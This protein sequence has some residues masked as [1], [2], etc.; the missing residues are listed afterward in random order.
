MSTWMASRP[1]TDG[2]TREIK[3]AT[4]VRTTARRQN[5][6]TKERD[7]CYCA[8]KG[9][10]NFG[11]IRMRA[12]RQRVIETNSTIQHNVRTIRPCIIDNFFIKSFRLCGAPHPGQRVFSN[13]L[14]TGETRSRRSGDNS[15]QHIR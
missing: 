13:F 10:P 9:Q 4:D 15:H 3:T 8:T 6:E 12:I 11:G 2:T 14:F 5:E 1:T 7:R